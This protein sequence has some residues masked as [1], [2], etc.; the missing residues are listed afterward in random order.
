MTGVFN[1]VHALCSV[2]ALAERFFRFDSDRR[3]QAAIE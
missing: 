3:G 2:V 1:P